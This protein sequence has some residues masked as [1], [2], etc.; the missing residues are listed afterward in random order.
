MAHDNAASRLLELLNRAKSIGPNTASINAWEQLL[1]AKSDRALLLSRLGKVI[2]LP[3]QISVILSNSVDT[4][5]GVAQHISDQFYAAFVTHKFNEKWEV[6]TSR[7]DVHVLNYLA[8]ASTL[9]ETKIKTK[10]LEEEALR[11]LRD[12][13]SELL[14]S[15]RESG[16]SSRIRSYVVMQLHDLI[17]VLDDY[18]ITG[19]EPIMRN[20]EAAVCRAYTDSGYKS[21]LKDDD[22]GKR[23]LACLS[24]AANLVTVAVGIPQLTQVIHLLQQS[25]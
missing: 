5:P 16:S 6:F 11:G 2:A 7:I 23:L 25:S 10:K 21:F 9:L 4:D 13:F 24:A 17:T 8:L 14:E 15:V 19:A 3:E 22:L 1:D 18:F 20:I 12:S